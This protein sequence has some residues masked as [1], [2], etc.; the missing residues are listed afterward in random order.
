MQHVLALANRARGVISTCNA[1]A[2]WTA[3]TGTPGLIA[4]NAAIPRADCYWARFMSTPNN[5]LVRYEAGPEEMEKAARVW[6]EGLG[7]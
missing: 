6:L 2:N 7:K 3:I 1:L 4:A 5:T